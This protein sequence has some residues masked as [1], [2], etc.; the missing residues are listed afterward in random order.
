M[1]PGDVV[2]RGSPVSTEAV[3]SQSSP[4]HPC[5]LPRRSFGVGRNPPKIL[6]FAKHCID[7]SR[8]FLV[9]DKESRAKIGLRNV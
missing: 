5:E 9:N 2:S 4:R 6:K 1:S 3:R 7:I 8:W